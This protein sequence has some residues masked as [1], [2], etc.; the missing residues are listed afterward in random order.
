MHVLLRLLLKLSMMSDDT[1]LAGREFHKRIVDG[2]S[3]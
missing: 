2:K 3:E 1:T